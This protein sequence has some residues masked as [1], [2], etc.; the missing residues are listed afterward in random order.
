MSLTW[1]IV[2]LQLEQ[3]GCA[4]TLD[5]TPGGLE[6]T[7]R[8]QPEHVQRSHHFQGDK[9]MK[10]VCIRSRPVPSQS[11]GIDPDAELIRA[12]LEWGLDVFSCDDPALV[13]RAID[14]RY[15]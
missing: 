14:S 4:V 10:P 5:E 6:E 13:F 2:G 11:L 12:R 8:T 3:I 15:L 7:A 9:A 1:G